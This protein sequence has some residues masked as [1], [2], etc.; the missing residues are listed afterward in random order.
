MYILCTYHSRVESKKGY[1]FK[2]ISE[3][4]DGRTNALISKRLYELFVKES[5]AT[6]RKWD[7]QLKRIKETK[8]NCKVCGASVP[9]KKHCLV[10]RILKAQKKGL[11]NVCTDSKINSILKKPA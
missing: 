6:L 9:K 4:Y 8:R 7:R 5:K 1:V 11:T 2:G 10:C 3:D